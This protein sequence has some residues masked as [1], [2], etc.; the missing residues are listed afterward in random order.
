LRVFDRHLARRREIAQRYA[1]ALA[2]IP[3]IELQRVEPSD[4]STWKDFTINVDPDGFGV[5]R[6]ALVAA[7][8]A[9]GVGTRN[10]FDPPVHRQTAY[11]P[12]TI[13]LPATDRVAGRVVSLPIYPSLAD[14]TVDAVVAVIT[15]VHDCAPA[16]RAAVAPAS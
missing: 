4:A 2:T 16:V 14:E 8:G 7:L 15:R 6:D 1:D 5:D 3:G 11:A 10:Y 9:E 12:C 13:D